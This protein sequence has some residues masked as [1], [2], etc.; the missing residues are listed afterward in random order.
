[1]FGF[2]LGIVLYL[3][4]QRFTA[5]NVPKLQEC[6]QESFSA[7]LQAGRMS[8]IYFGRQVSPA[9]ALFLEELERSAEALEDYGISVAKVNCSKADVEKY[10]ASEKVLKKS[11]LFRGSEVL[12][13]FDI[14]T[15]FDVNAIV[16]HVLFTVLFNEVRSVQIPA[17]L[18]SIERLAKGKVDVVF[19]HVQA[20]GLPEHRALMEAAFVYGT[21]YQFVLT[22]G[23]PVLKH[24]GVEDPSSLQAGLWFLH[25]KDVS[26]VSDRCTHTVMRKPLTTL[27]LHTFLQMMDVPLLTE[28][29]ADPAEVDVVYSHLHVPVLFLFAQPHTLALDRTTAESL[30]WRLRGEVG[31][32][33][34]HRGGTDATATQKYNAAYKLPEE[35]ATLK[36][37][38]FNSVED[39]VKLFREKTLPEGN[40]DDDEDE[41]EWAV[42]DVLDDEVAESVYRDRGLTLDLEPVAEL[43]GD[44][45]N[46]AVARRGLTA[47]LFY[48]KWDAVSMAV[49]QSFIEVAEAL[50][51]VLDVVLASVDCGEWTDVCSSQQISSYP[52]VLMYRPGEL[53][54]PYRGML[55]TDSL[56]RFILLS[57]TG[58]PVLLSCPSEAH[59][60]LQG[61]V[62]ERCPELRPVRVLGLFGAGQDP[63][64][65][66][67]KDAVRALRGEAH[68]GLF[69]GG[70][71]EKWAEELSVQLPALLVSRWPGV[72]S[73][74]H[75]IRLSSVQELL[76]LIRR[77]LLEPFPE[78]TVDN[79]PWYLEQKKPLLLLFAHDGGA[80]KAD[81]LLEIRG[82]LEKGQL[83]AYLPCWIHMGRTPAGRSVLETYLGFLPQ[84]PALVL[85]QLS[86]GG[87]V[88][89]FP[90]E[91]P[92]L[93]GTVLQWLHSV[94]SGMEK[95]TGVVTD[96][97][98]TPA[99]P[100]YDF[101]SIMD[102]E[103]PGYA[104]QR[105]PK[106]KTTSTKGPEEQDP[107]SPVNSPSPHR[108]SEL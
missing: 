8:F 20:L 94:E 57:H 67:F 59:T 15:V 49:L 76:T 69:A 90:T 30:A 50:K 51:D 44:T 31:V 48:V 55:G 99:V 97:T 98:W 36:Y 16:S 102:E 105:D 108:H 74:A 104:S 42:L 33:L 23:G 12:R 101:L 11:Y 34:I 27:N 25:C 41:D 86:T 10:C 71:A 37:I 9:I 83:D 39:A 103:M 21:K 61:G 88:F 107:G 84:L 35:G 38:T 2:I 3:L 22:T 75:A 65:S 73:Q 56:H 7:K 53:A 4:P 85:S 80:E 43:T 78:L 45:F 68:F 70:Q 87:E 72:R 19:G 95:S 62:G 17:E 89:H 46:G 58:N 1:M 5:A 100:F 81:A 91:R 47:V 26:R 63:G 64:I 66:V 18:L 54:Q 79:L 106:T 60:F 52:K 93:E 40:R 96:G 82:L 13:S 28:D 14:D 29:A 92:L 32:V 77:L 6:T 24:L